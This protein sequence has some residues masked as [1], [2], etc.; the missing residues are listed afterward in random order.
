MTDGRPERNED[1]FQGPGGILRYYMEMVHYCVAQAEAYRKAYNEEKAEY[2]ER[3]AT[4]HIKLL[5][6]PNASSA[7]RKA[8]FEHYLTSA[9]YEFEKSV[10][11]KGLI[12]DNQDFQRRA[13]MYS[14]ALTAMCTYALRRKSLTEVVTRDISDYLDVTE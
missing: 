6:S 3:V 5:S 12:A 8:R 2:A 11:G 13:D 7:A 14:N 10:R 4:S 9:K 1:Q